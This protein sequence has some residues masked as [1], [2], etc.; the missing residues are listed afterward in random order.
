[1]WLCVVGESKDLR[2]TYIWL[3]SK[4]RARSTITRSS[5][6]PCTAELAH[7]RG[8]LLQ[9][10]AYLRFVHR[11][12]I[13]RDKRNLRSRKQ[14]VWLSISNLV[15]HTVCVDGP[16]Q[17]VVELNNWPWL[18]AVETCIQLNLSTLR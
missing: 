13:A 6:M 4:A 3:G 12:G 10:K 18:V 15:I 14:T 1:M 8:K 16:G 7:A 17:Q 11:Y 5:V 9:S 2:A